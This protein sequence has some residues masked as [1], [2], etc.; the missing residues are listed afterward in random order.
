MPKI[1][2]QYRS[3]KEVGNLTIRFT[4]KEIQ[5]KT[6]TPILSRK[7]Y[8]FNSSGGQK[9]LNDLRGDA[10]LKQHKRN[11]E[12]LRD[13]LEIECIGQINSGATINSSLLKKLIKQNWKYDIKDSKEKIN[14][15]DERVSTA[16]TANL[17]TNAIEQIFVKYATNERELAKYK[18]LKNLILKYQKDLNYSIQTKDINNRF[19]DEFK[20]WCI[21]LEYSLSYVNA[22]LK[23]IRKSVNYAYENDEQNIIEISRQLNTFPLF[24]DKN[25]KS[26]KIVITLNYDE[27]DKIDNTEFVDFNLVE[28][29]KII[30]IGCETGLRYSDMNKLIDKNI[31]NVGGVNY[32]TFSTSKTGAKVKITIS[33]RIVYLLQ[34]YGLPSTK[35]LEDGN[36]ND[37][38]IN[39]DIKR[40][41]NRANINEKTKG[42]KAVSVTINGKKQRRNIIDFYPKYQLITTRTL[43]RSFATNYY[44]KIDTSLITD[45]TGHKTE[46]MLREYINVSDDSNVLRSKEQID[47]FHQKRKEEKNN[48][49]LTVLPKLVNY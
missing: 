32:W 38:K 33:Q 47:A 49:K 4:H 21:N 26:D 45:V 11:L 24:K 29:K 9:S 34:K 37:I 18:V 35:Y 48:I 14:K 16:K 30:L 27:L 42:L 15:E 28:A 2:F 17:L 36:N 44:G 46:K 41:C 3:K 8:W 5:V 13:K 19:A 20:N 43:R 25:F 40:V 1:T 22:Q 10:E 23:R 39:R 31:R 12:D 6:S 7:T